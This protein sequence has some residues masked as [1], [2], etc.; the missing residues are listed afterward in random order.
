[1]KKS[2]IW[3]LIL[4]LIL[5]IGIGA[6]ITMF[7]NNDPINND[8]QVEKTEEKMETVVNA[9]EIYNQS[10]AG[11]HEGGNL[12]IGPS[13][14]GVSNRLTDAQINEIIMNGTPVM[15]ARIV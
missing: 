1:M 15:P 9:E 2:F 5:G 7:L 3:I 4:L 13:L 8:K 6:G 10:C 12:S 11:C 14:Q